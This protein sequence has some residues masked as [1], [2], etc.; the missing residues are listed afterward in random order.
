MTEAVQSHPSGIRVVARHIGAWLIGVGRGACLSP[1][2]A[3][4]KIVGVRN[5]WLTHFF[6]RT[7]PTTLP[8][9]G[10]PR[11]ERAAWGPA[12]RVPAYR[13]FLDD[14]AVDPDDLFP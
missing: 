8:G 9:L 6:K 2:A 5:G 13:D 10:Q 12:K 3:L 4:L 14:H 1:P 11:A 7:P